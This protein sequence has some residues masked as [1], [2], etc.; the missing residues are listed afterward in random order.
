MKAIDHPTHR[1]ELTMTKRIF[2]LL[3]SI[4]LLFPFAS[5]KKITPT[6]P[7]DLPSTR[8][9][10]GGTFAYFAADDSNTALRVRVPLEWE[11]DGESSRYTIKE[12]DAVI[13]TLVL[14]EITEDAES[15]SEAKS[16]TY[17]DVLIKTYIGALKKSREKAAWYRICYSYKDDAGNNCALT[18]EVAESAIDKK[19]FEWFSEPTPMPIKDYHKIPSISLAGTNGKKSIAILGNSFV[20]DHFSGIRIILKDMLQEG[21]RDWSVT[22][23]GIGYATVAKYADAQDSDYKTYIDNI[24]NGK[25]GIVFMCGLY[26]DADVDALQKI[27]DVCKS[28][29]TKLVIFPAHNENSPQLENAMAKYPDLVCLN[30]RDEIDGLIEAGVKRSDFCVNDTHSHST[31]L[32]GY[33]GAKM[34]YKSLFGA[35]PPAL[36]NN[37]DVI[38]QATVDQKLNGITAKPTVLI[39][40]KNIYKLK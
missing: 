39:P 8:K 26:S 21:N 14:G 23:K 4:F 35:E 13:G 38:S 12:G 40:E 18:L 22:V 24:K 7:D 2:T 37:C 10:T 27:Y 20:Y 31:A 5:C 11:F 28:S 17:N 34:I 25:Y 15:M 32:A 36:S 1:T 3:L 33:V 9:S 30:W 6:A 16:E 19:A 29:K